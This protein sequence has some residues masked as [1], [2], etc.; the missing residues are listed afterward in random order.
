MVPQHEQVYLDANFI[1]AYF[2][3]KHENHIEANKL[4]AQLLIMKNTLYYSPLTVDEA[5]HAIYRNLRKT[6]KYGHYPPPADYYDEFKTVLEKLLAHQQIQ[7]I[8]FEYNL[9]QAALNAIDNIRAFTMQPRDAFHT[10]YLQDLQI[11]YIVSNDDKFDRL[12]PIK[13]ERLS[14]EKI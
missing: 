14:F 9:R 8:Q 12:K 6:D 10:A 5:L 2:V 11:N 4:M 13:I 7:F 3:E 1:V